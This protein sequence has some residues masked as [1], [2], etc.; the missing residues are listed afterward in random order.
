M[1]PTDPKPRRPQPRLTISVQR[2]T[3]ATDA[4]TRID[5]IRFARAAMLRDMETTV[6]IVNENE[7]RQLN[8]DYRHKDYATNVLSFVY[9][10]TPSVHGDLVL[11]APVVTREAAEQGKNIIA[12]YAHLIVHG[13][14]HLHGYDHLDDETA[15]VMEALE[16]D[17]MA[18]LGYANPYSTSEHL[19]HG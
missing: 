16:I 19:H 9:E 3:R 5:I 4:P 14:L 18:K 13:V 1:Q 6:R 7:G 11:C 8:A 15:T 10:T 17:I 12:H 2:G